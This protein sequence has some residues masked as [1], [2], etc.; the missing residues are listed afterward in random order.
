MFTID[1]LPLGGGAEES[2][3]G[4]NMT[5][6]EQWDEST[7]TY[8]NGNT[9]AEIFNSYNTKTHTDVNYTNAAIGAY[10]HAENCGT[11]SIGTYSHA[12]GQHTQ[13]IGV[14]AHSEGCYTIAKGNYSHAGGM[15]TISNMHQTVVGRYNKD[16]AGPSANT[17]DTSGSLF[18]VGNGSSST[19]SNAFRVANGTTGVY[20]SG[21][22]HSSGADYAEHFEWL[23]GNINN[24]DRRG[25]F[26]TL[27]GD[28]I[29]LANSADNYILGV[30]SSTPTVVGDSHEDEW[31]N[32]YLKD[33]FGARITEEIHIDAVRDNITEE[34]I[35][36]EYT[37]TQYIQNPD[38]DEE[39]EYISREN[40]K[41]WAIVGMI[42]KLIVVDD[43]TC[44]INGYCYPKE[45][46]VAT[47]ATNGYRVMKR[48]DDMHIQICLK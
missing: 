44:K 32:R 34:I 16:T 24:E 2:L 1:C 28:K 33:V 13:A 5:G 47:D 35:E 36:P 19:R 40:R 30:I 6:I 27:D 17:S 20:G 31:H 45:D 46:G 7:S 11:S 38:Y 21:S 43:G 23:D 22:Y 3:V 9:G 37:I 4:K 15:Y 8:V 41:E 39:Q 12:E 48:I 42:G 26:V 18:I 25:L 29:R 14:G 10:S